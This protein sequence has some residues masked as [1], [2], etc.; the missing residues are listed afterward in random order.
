MKSDSAPVIALHCSG[1]GAGQ[2]RQLG[3]T[4]GPAYTL[5]A[6]EHYGCERTGP[7]TGTHAFTLADEAARTIDLIDRSLSKV[8]LVGHSY[9]GGVALH[10]ALARPARI[11]S[12]VLYEPSTFHL[13]KVIGDS[14]ATAFTE[15]AKIRRTTAKGVITGD[16]ASA[17]AAFVNYWGGTGA[18]A[19]LRPTVQTALIRWVPK[20]PLDFRALIEE[21]T[22][23]A[24]Y[25]NLRMPVLVMRGERA[26]LPTRT[27]AEMLPLVA[28]QARLVVIDGAGHMGPFTHGSVVSELIAAHIGAAEAAIRQRRSDRSRSAAH[29]GVQW[30]AVTASTPGRRN[31]CAEQVA[32]A[33][34][35]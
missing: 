32:T 25:S 7:W 12:L 23:L 17:A 24:A 5:F 1:S 20:A 8:H 31:F 14:G 27:I 26:P 28:P 33:R 15:I 35:E 9:G 3:E 13:L 16:Y 21:P 29:G 6:P 10:V 2:W 18:W 22:P 4:L 34:K 19:A 30:L 11:A